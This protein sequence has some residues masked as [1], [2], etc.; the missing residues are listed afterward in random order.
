MSALA[1]MRERF[2]ARWSTLEPRDRRALRSGGI[3]L[4]VI[5]PAL[6]AWSVH[7]GLSTKRAEIAESRALA[8]SAAQR[9]AARMAAGADITAASDDAAAMQSSVLR[10]AARSGIDPA[11]MSIESQ[12]DDKLRLSLRDVPYD[13]VTSMVGAL[14]RWEGVSVVA[15][16]LTR[17]TPGRVEAVV[18]LRSP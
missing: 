4:A 1:R 11:S 7:N 6:L 14:T 2:E 10:A 12:P 9:V 15:A 13:S 16:H 8:A 18:V 5:L 17:T 3:V